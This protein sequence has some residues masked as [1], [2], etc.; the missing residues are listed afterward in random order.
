M[1]LALAPLSLLYGALTRTR[2]ALYR[3]GALAVAKVD[4]PVISVGNITTGGTGK[5]PLVEWLARS[6]AREGKRVCVLTRGYGRQDARRVVV[7]DNEKILADARTGGDEP[8]LLAE[9]LRGL[10]AVVADADRTAAARWAQAAL[11]SEVFILDDGFQHLRLARDLNIV[12][13][14]AT[15]PWGGGHLLPRGRLREP[16]RGLARAD[17]I[18]ITRAELARD[19][20]DLR[21]MAAQLS[22]GRPVF[23]A[24]THMRRIRPLAPPDEK[25]NLEPAALA[26]PL[27]AFCAIGNPQ[28]FFT[29]ARRA[30]CVL[31]QTRTFSD[32]HNYTQADVD[33]LTRAAERSGVRALLTTAKDA[34]KLRSFR[35]ALPCYVFEIALTL[36]EETELLALVRKT[37][38]PKQ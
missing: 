22:D 1:S 28:A 14:D 19:L 12:T 2:L 34:V 29:H 18:V 8:R 10:A 15:T 11:G 4:A 5:T 3:A 21:N 7:S 30:G 17:A 9:S 36:D 33:T 24:R 32:H 20:A 13:V 23:V 25:V 38:T 27:T 6:V 31:S 35:F 37:I 16:V 26:Q